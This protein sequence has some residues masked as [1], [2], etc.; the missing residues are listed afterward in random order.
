MNAHLDPVMQSI[1]NNATG[2]KRYRTW[3]NYLGLKL[4]ADVTCFPGEEEDLGRAKVSAQY[5]VPM[6]RLKFI[7]VEGIE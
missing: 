4:T 6:D 7:K 2:V 5:D 1:L 3:F